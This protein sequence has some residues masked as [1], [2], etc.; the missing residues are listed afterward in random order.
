MIELL[1]NEYDR[2]R[3]SF[4]DLRYGGFSE[5][6]LVGLGSLTMFDPSRVPPGKGTMHAWDY[7]PYARADRRSWDTT[8]IEYAEHMLAH[9]GRFI[10]GL[11]QNIIKYHCDSPLDMERTS[12][13]GGCDA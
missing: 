11:K 7:V 1:P 13:T 9:M 10:D 2:L 4:D 5:Y 8:K 12:V 3:R 6:P